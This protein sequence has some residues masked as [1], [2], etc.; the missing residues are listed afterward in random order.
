MASPQDRVRSSRRVQHRGMSMGMRLKEL[1]AAGKLTRVFCL[2][3]MCSPKW[4]EMLS[5]NRMCD[6]VWLDQEHGG[7]TIEQIEHAA[8]AARA[9]GMD[10]FVRLAPTDYATVMRPLE[11]G[12][13]G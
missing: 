10:S 13:G 2:G 4:V 8:R 1:L 3:Q 7:L 5:L 9:C 6:A 11:A 12:T